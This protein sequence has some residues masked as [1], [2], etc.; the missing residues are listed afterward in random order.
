[1]EIT[2]KGVMAPRMAGIDISL[3]VHTGLVKALMNTSH[4]RRDQAGQRQVV[5]G[6]YVSSQTFWLFL[7]LFFDNC[8][9]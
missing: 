2:G 7:C 3:Q 5:E 6:L 8:I 1:M 4:N 9:S